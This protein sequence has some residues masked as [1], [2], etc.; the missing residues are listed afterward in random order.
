MKAGETS[1]PFILAKPANG[2]AVSRG[3]G[4]GPRTSLRVNPPASD[5]FSAV[6]PNDFTIARKAEEVVALIDKIDKE[7]GPIEVMAYNVGAYVPSSTLEETAR[8]YFKIW[9]MAAF[10]GGRARGRAGRR[11]SPSRRPAQSAHR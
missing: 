11:G 6:N 2:S 10:S 3:R 7:H 4:A 9:G 8:K 5:Q 1:F